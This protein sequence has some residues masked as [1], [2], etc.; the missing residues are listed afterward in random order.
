MEIV[1]LQ[2]ARII[3]LTDSSGSASTETQ[4]ETLAANVGRYRFVTPWIR[5]IRDPGNM[6]ETNGIDF[7]FLSAALLE[8]PDDSAARG[9]R[10][11]DLDYV[12]NVNN[13]L[14]SGN[15][16]INGKTFTKA[17]V[18][19]K[20]PPIELPGG[21]LIWKATNLYTGPEANACKFEIDLVCRPY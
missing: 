1:R 8:S 10:F 20:I 5:V 3:S 2:E 14:N 12:I 19:G 13:V 16:I 4:A 21:L 7:S 15:N 18:S 6:L 9:V 11:V 17:A